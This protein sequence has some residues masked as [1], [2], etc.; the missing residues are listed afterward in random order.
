MLDEI[1]LRYTIGKYNPFE[2]VSVPILLTD[3]NEIIAG[4][5]EIGEWAASKS[6]GKLP[7]GD[8]QLLKRVYEIGQQILEAGRQRALSRIIAANAFDI[9]D[10][11]SPLRILPD[12]VNAFSSNLVCQYILRKYRVH[13]NDEEALKI[14]MAGCEELKNLLISCGGDYLCGGNQITLVDIVA[15]TAVSFIQPTPL[16]RDR[17]GEG[18]KPYWYE[19]SLQER[20]GKLLEWRE[21]IYNQHRGGRFGESKL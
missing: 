13:E 17:L 19:P 4:S 16:G 11:P 3:N 6:N 15:L 9:E 1:W 7:V 18:T 20:F 5:V 10:I 2:K 21:R 14:G 12:S 8:K